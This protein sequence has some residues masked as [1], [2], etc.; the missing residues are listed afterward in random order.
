MIELSVR[1]VIAAAVLASAWTLKQP[2]WDVGWQWAAGFAVYS[3]LVYF[4]ERSKNRNSGIAGFIAVFD[5]LF[6]ATV[7]ADTGQLHSFGF[8]VLVPMMWATGRF[9]SDAASM[10]PLVAAAVMVSSN[11][12]EGG[13]F[14]LPILLH[15]LGILVVGLLTNQKK[16]VTKETQVPIEVTREVMVKEE[17]DSQLEASYRSLKD[18]VNEL[19]KKGRRDRVAMRV[20][21]ATQQ[22]DDPYF[23][24]LAKTLGDACEVG[25]VAV[26]TYDSQQ[27]RMIAQGY[28]GV[29]PKTVRDLAFD[30]PSDLGDGQM[31]HHI[32]QRMLRLRDADSPLQISTVLLKDK[33]R[34]IGM[35]ALFE[36]SLHALDTGLRAAQDSAEALGPMVAAELRREDFQMRLKETEILYGVA[37]LTLGAETPRSMVSRVMR[38]LGETVRLDHLGVFFLD[39]EDAIQISTL[40]AT[41]RLFEEISFAYGTGLPGWLELGAP[42]V[43]LPDTLD[44]DRVEKTTAIKRRVGSYLMIPLTVDGKPYG[45]ITAATHSAGA[46]DKAKHNTLRVI[47]AETNQA[48]NRI[49]SPS[50]DPEGVMTP[51]E[52]YDAI[53]K[54]RDGH[55][56]Y[57][58]VLRREENIEKFGQ[59]AFDHALR[60]LLRGLRAKLPSGGAICRRDE[61]DYVAFLPT[62][63]ESEARKWS[64]QATASASL[65]R[66]VTP[67]GRAKIPLALRAKVALLRPQKHQVSKV[68][69]A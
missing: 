61:G 39:E 54:G 67:D 1:L 21:T 57:I 59:P 45:F 42:E 52:F 30:V 47:A 32:E 3:G 33:G 13:G 35:V 60:K 36:K 44:D 64:T 19:E 15:T 62:I 29:V 65:I 17:R 58:D 28:G 7:L 24:T 11:F 38:E 63:D 20:Y 56:V 66:L 48:L 55:L 18:H 46:I 6:V 34:L 9:N 16:I 51:G 68:N 25:G 10:A 22:S 31:R 8:L 14:T 43:F 41:N 37:S 50:T 23:T 12:F 53:R 26:Y 2:S 27:K 69:A 5:A 40:G 4:I 49:V